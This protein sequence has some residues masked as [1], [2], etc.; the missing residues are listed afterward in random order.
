MSKVFERLDPEVLKALAEL[1]WPILAAIILFA[2]LPTIIRV[3]KSRAF[4]IKYGNMEISVQDAADGLRKQIE[5][6]QNQVR[7]M[8]L[9]PAG[10]VTGTAAKSV[11]KPSAAIRKGTILWVDDNP[12]NNAHEIKKLQDDGWDISTAESTAVALTL[13]KGMTSPPVL[14]ISDMGRREGITYRR[15]AGLSL[16]RELR[17]RRIPVILYTSEAVVREYREQVEAAGGAGIT[18]SPMELFSMVE[19]TAASGVK[20]SNEF[21]P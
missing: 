18:A 9:Q 8:Q 21:P 16:I 3:A 14:V 7:S 13:L 15:T 20:I 5:D 11:Q 4:S 1:A 6:L 12:Q 17:E 10:V 2:L 19:K